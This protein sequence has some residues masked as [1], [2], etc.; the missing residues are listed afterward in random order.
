MLLYQCGCNQVLWGLRQCHQLG[1]GT[2]IQTENRSALLP[3][4]HHCPTFVVTL[5]DWATGRCHGHGALAGSGASSGNTI[6]VPPVW[7]GFLFISACVFSL[8]GIDTQKMKC[9]DMGSVRRTLLSRRHG[10]LTQTLLIT[11]E[12]GG[13][14]GDKKQGEGAWS[15]RGGGWAPFPKSSQALWGGKARE[16]PPVPRAARSKGPRCCGQEVLQERDGRQSTSQYAGCGTGT[17]Q[18]PQEPL[19]PSQTFFPAQLLTGFAKGHWLLPWDTLRATSP[20]AQGPPWQMEG[21]MVDSR[22]WVPPTC[23]QHPALPV[24][25]LNLPQCRED[26]HVNLAN[27]HI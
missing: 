21:P 12:T 6:F 5:G 1:T 8:L 19:M 26:P 16:E 22:M 17:S 2:P 27:K 4:V 10:L 23:V 13:R 11:S 3:R 9:S 18:R 7:N 25:H 24:A 14:G 15:G 20:V